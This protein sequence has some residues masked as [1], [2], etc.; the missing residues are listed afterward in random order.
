MI[1]AIVPVV[2][3]SIWFMIFIASTMHSTCPL[4][5]RVPTSTKGAAS[6]AGE[7]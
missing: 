5:T 4:T 6:G 7:R 3:D 1:A 2:S